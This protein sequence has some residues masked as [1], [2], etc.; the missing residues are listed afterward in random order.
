[1]ISEMDSPGKPMQ[2]TRS[3]TQIRVLYSAG[4]GFD[5]TSIWQVAGSNCNNSTMAAT[6]NK[7]WNENTFVPGWLTFGFACRFLRCLHE[8]ASLF[9]VRR[10]SSP[11]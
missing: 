11:L 7:Q 9:P 6:A 5:T 3:M 10:G 2:A 4:V 1:M 8:I